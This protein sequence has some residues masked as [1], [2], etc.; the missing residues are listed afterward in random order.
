MVK[1]LSPDEIRHLGLTLYEVNHDNIQNAQTGKIE[2]LLTSARNKDGKTAA[3]FDN[4]S[5]VKVNESY[6]FTGF[7]N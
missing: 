2:G 7:Y 6:T 1:C 3:V 5:S 4:V